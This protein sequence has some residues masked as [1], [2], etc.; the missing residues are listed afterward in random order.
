MTKDK[1]KPAKPPAK[2]VPLQRRVAIARYVQKQ[3]RKRTAA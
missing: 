3:N 1:S 2:K